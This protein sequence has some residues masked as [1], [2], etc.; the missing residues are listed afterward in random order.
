MDNLF[1][2]LLGASAVGLV[3]ACVALGGVSSAE[4]S[5]K[6]PPLPACTTIKDEAGCTAREDCRWV[7]ASIDPV[8]KKEKRRAYCRS[9]PK[10]KAPKKS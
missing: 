3:V 2:K 7:K 5:K 1:Q 6:T 10:P 9:K 8:T 4:E